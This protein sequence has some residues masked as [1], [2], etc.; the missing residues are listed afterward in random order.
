MRDDLTAFAKSM[1]E[2]IAP[3][4]TL[5]HTHTPSHPP[6][7]PHGIQLYDPNAQIP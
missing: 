5:H 1:A 6:T 7:S 2:A 4:P 3:T